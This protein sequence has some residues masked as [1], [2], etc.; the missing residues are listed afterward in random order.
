MRVTS[1]SFLSLFV[2]F[3]MLIAVPQVQA[4]LLD[5]LF[6]TPEEEG[7]NPAET[8]R[9]PFADDDAVIEDFEDIENPENSL[10]LPQKHRTNNVMAQWLQIALPDLVS[11]KAQGYERQYAEKVKSFSKSGA[12]AY[13][14][15]LHDQNYITTLKTGR[16]D[17]S[18]FVKG[19]PIVVN[20][21]VVDG[22]YQWAF[23]TD[24]MV[25]FLEQG[26]NEYNKESGDFITQE[27]V[28]TFHVGRVKGVKNDH[29]VLIETW[30]V[31]KK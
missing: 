23:Q 26:M 11:Y 28:V 3:F 10:P 24:I 29:G 20:E 22:R 6:P 5:F 4:G 12:E 16:Y 31:Q 9:A 15:F 27:Y 19:Y 2:C 14:K 25:T 8:L 30:N 17:I 1:L 7:P 21:G 18:G 13:V